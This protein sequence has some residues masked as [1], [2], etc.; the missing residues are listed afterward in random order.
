VKSLFHARSG[1]RHVLGEGVIV[2]SEQELRSTERAARAEYF[3]QTGLLWMLPE[4]ASPTTRV[5]VA[6]EHGKD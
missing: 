3:E 5:S 4:I 6:F 1:L 2:A